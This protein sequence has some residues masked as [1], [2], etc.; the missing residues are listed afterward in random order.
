VVSE[1]NAA[2]LTEVDHIAKSLANSEMRDADFEAQRDRDE[3]HDQPVLSVSPQGPTT[4]PPQAEISAF[5]QKISHGQLNLL[6]VT[7]GQFG[8]TALSLSVTGRPPS[9]RI[10]GWLLPNFQGLMVG[11]LIDAQGTNLTQQVAAKMAPLQ[12]TNVQDQQ[13]SSGPP[14]S[15]PVVKISSAAFKGLHFTSFTEGNGATRLT[16]FMDPNCTFCHVL[17]Q[18]IHAVPHYQQKFTIT[19]V[20]IGVIKPSSAAI[21]AAILE[22]GGVR[23]LDFD[24]TNFDD[25]NE[26][27][28]LS[29]TTNLKDLA[30]IKA[31][32]QSWMTLVSSNHQPFAT[33]TLVINGSQLMV[34]TPAQESLDA[35]GGVSP[36]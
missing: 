31:N 1:N 26:A 16:L 23:A 28:G 27:G 34:G 13:P 9:F 22:K 19:W 4:V 3:I 29:P 21:A 36:D 35:L 14:S 6:S 32:N 17:W 15:P 8:L 20:P 33:P 2:A 7:P 12:T 11:P 24:E 5:V 18:R 30:L 25:V 10:I